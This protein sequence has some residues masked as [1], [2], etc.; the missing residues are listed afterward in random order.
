MVFQ[1]FDKKSTGSAI[2]SDIMPNQ[3]LA[4]ELHKPQPII[5]NFEKR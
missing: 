1:F 2:K 3:Q 4:A 5:K